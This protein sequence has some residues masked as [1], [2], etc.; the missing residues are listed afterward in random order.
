MAITKNIYNV[1]LKILQARLQQYVNHELPYIQGGF[2]KGREIRDL[3]ANIHGII[4]KA[5]EFQKNIYFCF[6]D[7]AKAFDCVD[8]S[9]FNPVT[10]LCPNLCN[11]MDCSMPGFP[12][13]HQL[14]GLTQTHV[15][16]VSDVIQPSHPLWS[17]SPPAFNLSQHQSFSNESVL[18]IRRPK[19]WSF[20][21]SPS[22]EY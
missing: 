17:P 11:P 2:R 14:P 16:R 13:H 22:N 8:H 19:Y 15:H 5:R 18:R 6:L 4:E 1:K 3:I 10:H 20:S 21:L 9:Q 7:Y 12:V